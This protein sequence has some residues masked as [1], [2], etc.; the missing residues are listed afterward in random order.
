MGLGTERCAAWVLHAAP[1]PLPKYTPPGAKKKVQICARHDGHR[2]FWALI[3]LRYR[4]GGAVNE[5]DN[6]PDARLVERFLTN[7]ISAY[8][9]LV[10]RYEK[11]IYNYVLRMVGRQEDAEDIAQ[12]T[13]VRVFEHAG[14]LREA[15]T[16]RS[17]LWSIAVNL[18]NDHF[19]KQRYRAHSSIYELDNPGLARALSTPPEARSENAEIGRLID[20]AVQELT[21]EFRIP[22]VLREYDGLSYKE[23]ADAVGCPI[24]TVR[25]RLSTARLT[26][27]KRL[28]FLL[29]E[30]L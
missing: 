30:G 5:A 20:Q 28:A 12:E 2:T 7:D 16:F 21:P 9:I 14:E 4:T 8:E 13:F 6:I 15:C 3:L 10:D 18:C 27:R 22:L 19:K 24:G 26:L 23:I 1:V 29:E 25:S 11:P 17:W